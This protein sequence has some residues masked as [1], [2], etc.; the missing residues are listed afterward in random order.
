MRHK[1][2]AVYSL[3]HAERLSKLEDVIYP[4]PCCVFHMTAASD[5]SDDGVSPAG[6]SQMPLIYFI[7]VIF[8]VVD[9]AFACSCLLAILRVD[10][11]AACRR[12]NPGGSGLIKGW[13]RENVLFS[14]QKERSTRAG[15]PP[16]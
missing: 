11:F 15:G 12:R 1:V 3:L 7:P 14:W 5:V 16:S 9:V 10:A 4:P 2:I 6:C 8:G 13:D